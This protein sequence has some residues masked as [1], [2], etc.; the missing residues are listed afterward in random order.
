MN[1]NKKSVFFHGVYRQTHPTPVT[2]AKRGGSAGRMLSTM[3]ENS[4]ASNMS[5]R[6]DSGRDNS[7]ADEDSFVLM[8]SDRSTIIVQ[9]VRYSTLVA[10]V[11]NDTTFFNLSCIQFVQDKIT[12]PQYSTCAIVVQ[13]N[14]KAI[15]RHWE[16]L[17]HDKVI[18]EHVVIYN[19]ARLSERQIIT[20]QLRM[21]KMTTEFYHCIWAREKEI[22][23][24]E[25]CIM[26]FHS[27]Y[28]AL[29][30]IV[31]G[32]KR[33]MYPT[34]KGNVGNMD[35]EYETSTG[36]SSS[37][38]FGLAAAGVERVLESGEHTALFNDYYW[39]VD[40]LLYMYFT[41][42]FH[43]TSTTFGLASLLFT[44]LFQHPSFQLLVS[45]L[46]AHPEDSDVARTLGNKS[47]TLKMWLLGFRAVCVYFLNHFPN[48]REELGEIRSLMMAER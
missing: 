3:S 39:I 31:G 4:G 14:R 48:S 29:W 32:G 38:G 33:D 47:S 1:L 12:I 20:L 11:R 19:L 23:Q 40:E 6:S 25:R 37:S 15:M 41:E 36:F 42:S 18:E 2:A 27:R 22:H 34:K 26:Q 17:R 21:G 9:N 45:F 28:R 10:Q 7:S 13:P 44:V 24:L 43:N 30:G 5:K 46:N 35:E 8:D 16:E